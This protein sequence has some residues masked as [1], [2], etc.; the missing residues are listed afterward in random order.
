MAFLKD[1]CNI[2]GQRINHR[3][4]TF[5]IWRKAPLTCATLIQELT[6]FEWVEGNA[7]MEYLGVLLFQGRT[8]AKHFDKMKQ[9]AVSKMDSWSNKLLST[10]EKMVLINSV[11]CSIPIYT[12]VAYAVPKK[13]TRNMESS[14]STFLWGE[15]SRKTKETL[16]VMENHGAGKRGGG[17]RVQIPSN[18]YTGI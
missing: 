16:E 11:L 15:V 9:K 3:K 2:S 10:G 18:Y 5:I 1:Y 12:F 14:Y 4:S 17:S 7:A 6:G 13:V 8:S